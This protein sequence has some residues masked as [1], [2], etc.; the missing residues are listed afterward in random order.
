MSTR[1]TPAA[2]NSVVASNEHQAIACE[3]A[4]MHEALDTKDEVLRRIAAQ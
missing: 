3:L 4:D 2:A 1:M